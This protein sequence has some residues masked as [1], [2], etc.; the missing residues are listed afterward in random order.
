MEIDKTSKKVERSPTQGCT[1][2]LKPV[3]KS[4]TQGYTIAKLTIS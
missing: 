2:V 4:P 1:I 3:E